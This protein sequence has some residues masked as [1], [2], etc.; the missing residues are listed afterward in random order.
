MEARGYGDGGSA[1]AGDGGTLDEDEDGD[2]DEENDGDAAR[3]AEEAIYGYER[4][5]GD[6]RWAGTDGVCGK[7][8]KGG[9][10]KNDA[11]LHAVAVVV[12]AGAGDVDC[13][14]TPGDVAVAASGSTQPRGGVVGMTGA[15]REVRAAL[16]DLK[17]AAKERAEAD[18]RLGQAFM[19]G[20]VI[21]QI[22]LT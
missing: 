13:G 12:D 8:P 21:K 1:G 16:R 3:R 22:I 10:S 15:E 7:V 11:G 20:K 6:G 4:E 18:R 5:E 9:V 17:R 19:V 2:D 14:P